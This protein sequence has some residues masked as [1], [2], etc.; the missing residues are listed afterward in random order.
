[1]RQKYDCIEN[2]YFRERKKK[3]NADTGISF[4]HI[5]KMWRTNVG[6]F[7]VPTMTATPT[8]AVCVWTLLL[9]SFCCYVFFFYYYYFSLNSRR[10]H[11]CSNENA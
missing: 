3:W 5:E 4:I 11:Y 7:P 10:F 6:V 1:M 2:A 9:V 8:M